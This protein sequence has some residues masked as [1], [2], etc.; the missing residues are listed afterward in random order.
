MKWIAVIVVACAVVVVVFKLATYLIRQK[1]E[2]GDG[3]S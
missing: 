3:W 1:D 2:E